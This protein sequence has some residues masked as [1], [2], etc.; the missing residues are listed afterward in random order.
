MNRSGCNEKIE[1]DRVHHLALLVGRSI[2]TGCTMLLN[3][4]LLELSLATA[5]EGSMHDRWIGLLAC[6]TG[7]A[8]AVRAQT[9]HYRQHDR[10]VAGVEKRTGSLPEL[11]RRLVR[12]DARQMQW[13]ISQRQAEALLRVHSA[14][15]SA[16]HRELLRAYV[17]CG[18]RGS[19]I[20]RITTFLRYG[21]YRWNS[22]R[23]LAK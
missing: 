11:V 7:K 22:I 9:L 17:K 18:A 12:R 14:E 8:C 10:N 6:A 21:L 19:R 5:S 3:S 20:F 16:D 4:R 13:E 23:D 2:V 15:L 1:P